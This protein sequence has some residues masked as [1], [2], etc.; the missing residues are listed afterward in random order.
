M[1]KFA[2]CAYNQAMK[3]KTLAETN[4]HLKDKTK[5]REQMV[6]SLASSTAIETDEPIATI[7]AKLKKPR[8][9]RYRVTLA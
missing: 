4:P 2:G 1:T 3:N 9:L 6:R 5:A 7:E 8:A